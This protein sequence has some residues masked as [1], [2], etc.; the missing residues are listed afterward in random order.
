MSPSSTNWINVFTFQ[1]GEDDI[2]WHMS[3][4]VQSATPSQAA[5]FGVA[6]KQQSHV[7]PE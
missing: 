2:Y 4:V 7:G 6:R 1:M 5:V 3:V